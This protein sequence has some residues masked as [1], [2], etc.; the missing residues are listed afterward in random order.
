MAQDPKALLEIYK[1]THAEKL[2]TSKSMIDRAGLFLALNS[3]LLSF[4]AFSSEGLP[5]TF[6]YAALGALAFVDVLWFFMNERNRSYTR[7]CVDHLARMEELLIE[8]GG[9]VDA[10]RLFFNMRAFAQS[11]SIRLFE[12]G[13]CREETRVSCLGRAVRI[14][15]AF[16][17]IAA[18]F[19]LLNVALVVWFACHGGAF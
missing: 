17:T 1:V 8:N 9:S 12:K 7:Y 10:P 13:G 16:S 3:G 5:E 6:V 15:V 4:V 14:E 18:G 19:F 11:K 2:F